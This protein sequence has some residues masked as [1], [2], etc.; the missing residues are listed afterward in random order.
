MLST[1]ALAGGVTSQRFEMKYI[2]TEYQAELV[3]AF[4]QPYVFPDPKAKFGH[5]YPLSSVYLDSPD[6]ALYWSSNLGE[7]KRF[8][9]RVRTYTEDPNEPVF[10]EIKSRLNGIVMKKRAIVRK[11]WIRP[12]FHGA[13][14]PREALLSPDPSEWENLELFRKHVLE[15][16]AIP[17]LHVRYMREAYMSRDEDPVR[18]TFD[19]R[20][21]CLPTV[22]AIDR[23]RLNGKGWR[24][25][26]SPPVILE[27][28]FTDSYPSW[29]QE[30]P[31]RFSLLRDSFA[32]YVMCVRMLKAEGYDIKHPLPGEGGP[33]G[34]AG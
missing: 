3:R 30:I 29:V 24:R 13:S 19:S 33:N 15:L 11:D 16:N 9:L 25:L 23:I 10:F 21:A 12:F 2:L 31:Q 32:K 6:L 14:L 8:K 26:L 20:I 34:W 22:G 5:H 18:I 28:K 1:Q 7:N 17:R 27:V 4:I